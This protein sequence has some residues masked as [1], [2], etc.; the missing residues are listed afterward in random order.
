MSQ[1][2][3]CSALARLCYGVL[4]T[5]SVGCQTYSPY[6]Y[7]GYPSNYGYPAYNQPG[8]SVPYGGTAIPQGTTVTPVPDPGGY[9]AGAMGPNPYNPGPGGVNGAYPNGN[10]GPAGTY[11]PAGNYGPTQGADTSGDNLGPQGQFPSSGST[12]R[13]QLPPD[14]ADTMNT[15]AVTTPP[16]KGA[17]PPSSNVGD[18]AQFNSELNGAERS[19]QKLKT[20]ENKPISTQPAARLEVQPEGVEFAPPVALNDANAGQSGIIQTAQHVDSQPGRE[21]R[22]YGRAPNGRAWFRGLVDYD[23]Q[24]KAWYLIYNPEPDASDKQGGTIVLVD[25]PHL[26]QIKPDDVVLVEGEFDPSETDSAGNLKYRATF[27]RRL[28]R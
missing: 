25:H 5:A 19:T 12:T 13:P 28:V 4:L 6:G 1:S 9:P 18:P 27:I 22:P 26:K 16:R 15:P 24:E 10:Y 17:A 2:Q 14:D 7:G 3:T 8:M 23:E 20:M 21:L 11:G